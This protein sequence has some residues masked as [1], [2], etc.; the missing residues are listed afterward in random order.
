MA[1][2]SD[3]ARERRWIVAAAIVAVVVA[4][5]AG[6][7][8]G[9]AL[10]REPDWYAWRDPSTLPAS[11]GNDLVKYGWQL[12][13]DTPRYIGKT[14]ADPAMRYAGND[15]ACTNCHL[16]AGLKPFAASF[17]STYTSYPLSVNDKV[18]TLTDRINGCMTRSMNGEPLPEDGREM[19]AF[20]AYIRYLGR[21][22]PQ[23]VRV[24][25]MGLLTLG[26][27]A[28]TPSADRG[29]AVYEV[30]CKRC[31]GGAGLGDPRTPP[32]VGWAVPPLWGDGS[33]NAE[34]GMDSIETAAAFVRANMPRGV[35]YDSPMLTV[36]QAWD[37]AAHLTSEARPAGPAAGPPTP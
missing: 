34:A 29:K 32:G 5:G 13:V 6:L 2:A 18:I 21:G 4:A 25:G 28:E 7:G 33:F 15:L 31:H 14:A 17:V 27:P 35:G 16:D 23:G 24:A 11:A 8:G 3:K 10:W 26:K 1:G 20:L 37:V 9:Y 30:N 12:V 19:Q 36:Q 22:T